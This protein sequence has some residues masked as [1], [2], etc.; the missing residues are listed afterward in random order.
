MNVVAYAHLKAK[1][2]RCPPTV[3]V[4]VKNVGKQ[5]EIPNSAQMTNRLRGDDIGNHR[6]KL[7]IERT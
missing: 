7:K 6:S 1:K 4:K 2:G 3:G 5:N